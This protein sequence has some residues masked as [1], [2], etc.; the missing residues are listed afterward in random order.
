[1]NGRL[2]K[3][4]QFL[5]A[6]VGGAV[7]ATLIPL[8]WNFFF[9][10]DKFNDSN[11]Y[12]S[13]KNKVEISGNQN[14]GITQNGVLTEDDR[15]KQYRANENSISVEGNSNIGLIQGN[16]TVDKRPRYKVVDVVQ[17]EGDFIPLFESKSENTVTKSAELFDR[18]ISG[19]PIEPNLAFKEI[20][21]TVQ[22]TLTPG[23]EVEILEEPTASLESSSESPLGKAMEP[24]S[25]VVKVRVLNG[26]HKG[27]VGWV[28]ALT[29][30]PADRLISDE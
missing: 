16:I 30:T 6:G 21:S 8:A 22:T 17:G 1:M 5:F 10:T 11:I 3:V 24:F 15:S 4:L 12:E 19:E 29:I 26:S 23:T 18:L 27:K 9:D 14:T 7:V 2:V 13:S 20:F 28:S 25:T